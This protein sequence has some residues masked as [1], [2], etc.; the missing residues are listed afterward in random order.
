MAR[1]YF[2]RVLKFYHDKVYLL[3]LILIALFLGVVIIYNHFSETNSRQAIIEQALNR[4]QTV[5]RS[6][7]NSIHTF[8]DLTS[9]S[10]IL[11][12]REPDIINPNTNTQPFLEDFVS[13][14]QDTPVMGAIIINDQGI[15]DYGADQLGGSE[16]GVSIAD[17]KYFQESK[18]AKPKEV[19][20]G[21]PVKNRLK[22]FQDQY[23]ITI[24]T[25]IYEGENFKG[26]LGAGVLLSELAEDF[27]VPLKRSQD[28]QV[29]LM[30]SEGE[31]LYSPLKELTG[32]NIPQYLR[33]YSF[34]G[35]QYLAEIIEKNL[36]ERG[37]KKLQLARP[38]LKN[39]TLLTSY[40]LAYSP[41]EFD[42]QAWYLVS[43]TPAKEILQSYQFYQK[44]KLA[45]FVLVF[46]FIVIFPAFVVY[47]IN[48]KRKYSY[49]NGLSNGKDHHK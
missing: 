33:Q 9:K 4:E 14:W 28:S 13:N 27:L 17:R 40:L 2:K 8:L 48:I 22:S 45:G 15:I 32:L 11:L 20:F 18:K 5:V 35:S 16:T 42:G 3:F 6:G 36:A 39:K 26:V 25:P 10:L 12:A 49:F 21:M 30:S 23:I 37:E 29:Y 31:M 34:S 24:S 19:F 41:I 1:N 43:A 47:A 44:N 46:F 38:D 7:R